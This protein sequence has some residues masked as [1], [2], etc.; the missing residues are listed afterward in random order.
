MPDEKTHV[1]KG[2]EEMEREREREKNLR[3]TRELRF[4]GCRRRPSLFWDIN[5]RECSMKETRERN[6]KEILFQVRAINPFRPKFSLYKRRFHPGN[7]WR[8][9]GQEPC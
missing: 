7:H 5:A 2:D 9:D 4:V 8:I 3:Y 1:A 6:T